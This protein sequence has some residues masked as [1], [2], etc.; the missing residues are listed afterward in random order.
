MFSNYFKESVWLSLI[1]SLCLAVF[2]SLA[3]AQG[4]G[5]EGCYFDACDQDV[6]RERD[7]FN[8]RQPNPNPPPSRDTQLVCTTLYGGNCVMMDQSFPVGQ[9]CNCPGPFGAR[10]DGF[11]QRVSGNP[12]VTPQQPQ[13]ASQCVTQFGSCV[14]FSP[15]PFGSQCS[16][17]N[18]FGGFVPGVSQ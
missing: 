13:M 18:A 12:Q 6:V 14:L 9:L 5:G 4:T 3:N 15:A 10:I 16:C 1:A 17:L 8:E 2:G 7:R 11:T